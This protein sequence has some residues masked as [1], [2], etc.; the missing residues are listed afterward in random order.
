LRDRRLPRVIKSEQDFRYGLTFES[1]QPIAGP[2]F[3]NDDG[4]LRFGI[5]L[6]NFSSEPIK[7]TVEDFDVRI[8]NRALPVLPR[9]A[10]FGFMARGARRTSLSTA[11]KRRDFNGLGRRLYGTARFIILYGHPELS[12][13][14]KLTVSAD[15]F[16][17]LTAQP[18]FGF[19]MN[20]KEE[21]DVAI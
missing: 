14:R 6:R 12:P 15:I 20:I 3:A 1:F 5:I 4:E 2:D 18:P 11:F 13:A 8:G 16:L 10:L 17:E 21:S 7:Y 9:G 19:G